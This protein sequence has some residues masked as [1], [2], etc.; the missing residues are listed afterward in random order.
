MRRLF[1]LSPI[2]P[3]FAL[4]LAVQAIFPVTSRADWLCRGWGWFPG[5]TTYTSYPSGRTIPAG[6]PGPAVQP[7]PPGGSVTPPT[8]PPSSAPGYY[9]PYQAAS[10]P[11]SSGYYAPPAYG[12]PL[13]P[14]AASSALDDFDPQT[15]Y[16]AAP[17]RGF[18]TILPAVAHVG[19]HVISDLASMW[20]NGQSSGPD[21]LL[22]KALDSFMKRTNTT[23]PPT[24]GSSTY[25]KLVGM[26]KRITGQTPSGANQPQ[27]NERTTHPSTG[28]SSGGGPLIKMTSTNGGEQTVQIGNQKVVW[29]APAGAT[30]QIEFQAD[31]GGGNQVAPPAPGGN[32]TPPT[33]PPSADAEPTAPPPP[34]GIRPPVGPPRAPAAPD[35]SVPPAS[36]KRN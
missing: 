9:A 8:P 29:T 10:A 27:G 5:T 7:G 28:T 1:R 13:T 34:A 12:A 14:G 22:T 32:I 24:R 3:P 4:A 16:V 33:P 21:D 18:T 23:T 17:Q 2:L 25:A 35:P 20:V 30:I 26:V 36:P 31:E 15:T 19:V 11:S 6:L